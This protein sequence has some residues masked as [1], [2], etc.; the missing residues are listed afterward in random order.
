MCSEQKFAEPTR[1][2][3]LEF[4]GVAVGALDYGQVL[5]DLVACSQSS[6]TVSPALIVA[7]GM[8]RLA[9]GMPPLP[10]GKH[11]R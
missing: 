3:V 7:E 6:V 4:L 1:L 8:P 5:L 11:P 9:E 10:G 2:A